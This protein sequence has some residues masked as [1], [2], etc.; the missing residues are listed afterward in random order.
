MR[1]DAIIKACTYIGGVVN[2]VLLLSIC[3]LDFR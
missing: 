2:L 1:L 3:S